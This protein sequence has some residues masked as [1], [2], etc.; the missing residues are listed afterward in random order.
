MIYTS[1]DNTCCRVS[2]KITSFYKL[3]ITISSYSRKPRLLI[4]AVCYLFKLVIGKKLHQIFRN[5]S[6]K[7]S[8]TRF[9]KLSIV[10][11]FWWT[12]DS[13]PLQTL[14]LLWRFNLSSHV[15]LV[16]ILH[17]ANYAPLLN[18]RC[19]NNYLFKISKYYCYLLQNQL[20]SKKPYLRVLLLAVKL[21]NQMW[22]ETLYYIVP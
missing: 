13:Q 9:I 21:I 18:C 1:L 7:K 17:F 15:T 22:S 14:P 11:L 6:L 16:S 19:Y 20:N 4:I 12:F 2:I 10:F 8:W 5:T 3:A